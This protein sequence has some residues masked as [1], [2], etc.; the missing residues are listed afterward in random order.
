MKKD[1]DCIR[2]FKLTAKHQALPQRRKADEDDD[3]EDDVW[4]VK[5]RINKYDEFQRK[6]KA[7]TLLLSKDR[8]VTKVGKSIHGSKERAGWVEF[9]G[10]P[11]TKL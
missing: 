5:Q 6:A 11:R 9:R 10:W 3:E 7:P 4:S 1:G 8:P 2:S